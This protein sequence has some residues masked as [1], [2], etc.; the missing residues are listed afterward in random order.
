MDVIQ[1]TWSWTSCD[2]SAPGRSVAAEIALIR[3]NPTAI[4][5][6]PRF[7]ALPTAG[8][9][10]AATNGKIQTSHALVGAKLGKKPNMLASIIDQAL[11]SCME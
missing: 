5:P 11:L 8:M 10:K 2:S 3:A 7:V 4:Q 6:V 9:I 1:F